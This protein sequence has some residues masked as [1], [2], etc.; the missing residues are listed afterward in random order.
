MII[1]WGCLKRSPI[2]LSCSET[3]FCLLKYFRNSSIFI[4]LNLFLKLFVVISRHKS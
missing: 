3:L 1:Y 2:Y 4:F